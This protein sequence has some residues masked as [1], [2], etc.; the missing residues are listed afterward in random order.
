MAQGRDESHPYE[1]GNLYRGP[2]ACPIRARREWNTIPHKMID[3]LPVSPSPSNDP[4]R[5]LVL[6]DGSLILPDHA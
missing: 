5:C 6:K 4:G 1:H 3:R 2:R